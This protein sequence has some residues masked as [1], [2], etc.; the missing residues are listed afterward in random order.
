MME[1]DQ[2]KL[3]LLQAAENASIAERAALQAQ[4]H[5]LENVQEKLNLLQAAEN[6]SIVERE[7]LQAQV[8]EL[9]DVASKC[10]SGFATQL[11]ELQA[12]A[13]L[14]QEALQQELQAQADASRQQAALHQELQAN[15]SLEQAALR[16]ELQANASLEQAASESR[17]QLALQDAVRNESSKCAALRA[18]L[19]TTGSDFHKICAVWAKAGKCESSP[20]IMHEVCKTSCKSDNFDKALG[21]GWKLDPS[22]SMMCCCDINEFCAEWA[23]QGMCE[24]NAKFMLAKCQYSCGAC[25][26]K[27]L[28][29][30]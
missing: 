16:Q 24:S 12:N 28:T 6:V 8:H 2:E 3:R 14:Q 11:Q 13:T 25:G 19:G 26:K 27:S 18:N 7:A 20:E 22:K 15:A 1:A 10:A 29:E 30:S 4:V 21:S 23:E 17:F 9:Q 5:E